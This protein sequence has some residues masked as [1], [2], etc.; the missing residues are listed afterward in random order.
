LR[1]PISRGSPVSRTERDEGGGRGA[2]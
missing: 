2:R 1:K